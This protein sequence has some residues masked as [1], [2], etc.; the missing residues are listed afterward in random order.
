M[1]SLFILAHCALRTALR[2]LS[3]ACRIHLTLC[4]VLCPSVFTKSHDCQRSALTDI[5]GHSS[6]VKNETWL[7]LQRQYASRFTYTGH[8]SGTALRCSWDTDA[9]SPYDTDTDSPCTS[10]T[11]LTCPCT[12]T[13]TLT[14]K[15]LYW[16][17]DRDMD[18]SCTSTTTL[19]VR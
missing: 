18:S 17:H 16:Y 12:S 14:R 11:T 7:P 3:T 10:T 15:S 8:V 1:Y 6:R 13:M 9:D 19:T 5:R 4:F 2:S